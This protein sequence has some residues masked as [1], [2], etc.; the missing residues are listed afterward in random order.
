MY[1][2]NVA[3]ALSQVLNALLAG[4]PDETLSARSGRM[5]HICPTWRRVAWVIDLAAPG[6][7]DA[8][9]KRHAERYPRP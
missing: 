4:D 8:A 6:H 5:K 7:T 1:F 3:H 2:R 9:A